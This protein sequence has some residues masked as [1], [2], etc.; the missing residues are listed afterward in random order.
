MTADQVA[1]GTV[2]NYRGKPATIAYA[3]KTLAARTKSFVE[4]VGI[5][6]TWIDDSGNTQRTRMVW[7]VLTPTQRWLLRNLRW[8]EANP[9]TITPAQRLTIIQNLL[10]TDLANIQVTTWGS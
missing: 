6:F 8:P 3:W 4:P 5:E 1:A 2:I 7:P 9:Q 10:N